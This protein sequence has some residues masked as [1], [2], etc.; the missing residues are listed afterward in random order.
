MNVLKP[1]RV[2]YIK[3]QAEVNMKHNIWEFQQQIYAW[4][5]ALSQAEW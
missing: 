3:Q 1:S 5:Y 4:Y 2:A